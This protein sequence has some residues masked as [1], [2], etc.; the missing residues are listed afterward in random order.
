MIAAVAFAG[1][2]ISGKR[3]SFIRRQR[4]ADVDRPLE[5]IFVIALNV[6]FFGSYID[7]FAF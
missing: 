3:V 4:S 2:C 7:E 6:A 5:F 1:L